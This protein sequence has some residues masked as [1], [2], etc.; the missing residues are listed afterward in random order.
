MCIGLTV[1]IVPPASVGG[2][3]LMWT[4]GRQLVITRQNLR[5]MPKQSL[6]SQTAGLFALYST[7][8]LQS[9]LL[10]FFDG[11]ATA[12]SRARETMQREFTPP[13]KSLHAFQ[14]PQT[15]TE[16]YERAGRPILARLGA[17]SLAFF[18][19]GA[20]QTYVAGMWNEKNHDS[21]DGDSLSNNYF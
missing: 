20:V 9:P 4:Y 3:Y 2:G 1:M 10:A 15:L 6:A 11:D 7:Y 16:V 14:P 12:Q 8:K 13:H 5:D 18:C 19:A 17:V 21:T